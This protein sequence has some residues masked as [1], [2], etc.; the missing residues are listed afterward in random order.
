LPLALAARA[1]ADANGE[2]SLRR[3]AS[4]VCGVI[5]LDNGD[6]V[7]AI[8]H[9]IA[10]L[11]IAAVEENRERMS[12]LWSNIGSAAMN[13]GNYALGERCCGRALALLENR[14]GPV[15][16]RFLALANLA[17]ACHRLGRFEEGLAYAQRA[18]SEL[19]PEVRARERFNVVLLRRDLVRLQVECGQVEA[20]RLQVAELAQEAA[21]VGPR[22][23]IA[24]EVARAVYESATGQHDVALTRLDRVIAEAR[25][26]PA[27]LKDVLVCAIRCEEASGNA[28][29]AL[30]RLDELSQH[31]Y[32]GH[33]D[34]V[35]E[36]IRRVGLQDVQDVVSEHVREEARSRLISQLPPPRQPEG[37]KALQRLGVRA[38]M[39]MDESGWHGMR[40]GALSR[41]LAEA[42]GTPALQAREI[43]LAAE[44]HDLG[45]TAVPAEILGKRGPLNPAE[46]QIVQRHAP[47][48]AEML[49][50]GRHPRMLLAH[51]IAR[52]HH[53]R[54]D[55]EGYPARVGGEFIPYAAR[56][57]A[58]ADAYDMMVCGN[59]NTRAHTMG[60]ALDE[61]RCHAGTQF[62]PALVEC[63]DDMIRSEAGGR[64][65][66]LTSDGGMED[67][68]DLVLSLKEDRGFA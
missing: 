56:I 38:V 52:Y 7:G 54:Y 59:G 26:A 53:A 1:A 20:A 13:A 8:E 5:T 47:A 42:H 6:V 46:R 65:L 17:N 35:R 66:D 36:Q 23:R 22:A 68:Q 55:G 48:G 67:F 2:L 4:T 50:E 39:P 21:Q 10:A 64:G 19:T 62:D 43:G 33:I 57:C 31:V 41:L 49:A 63:F 24:A 40:V 61:L 45:M 32:A 30:V 37:W 9:Y 14:E 58:V 15:L 25:P 18:L 44:L 60:E 51:D 11:R 28:A 12:G 3:F 27:A 34:E 16:Q 29:R